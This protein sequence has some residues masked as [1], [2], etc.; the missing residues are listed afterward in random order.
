MLAFNSP[1][2]R[3]SCLFLIDS[4]EVTHVYVAA[5]HNQI[6][7]VGSGVIRTLSSAA[8]S[9]RLLASTDEEILLD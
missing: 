5:D 3:P 9:S 1:P 6:I 4:F 8:S 7:I 2:D